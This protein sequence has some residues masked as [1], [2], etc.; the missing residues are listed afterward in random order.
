MR[1]FNRLDRRKTNRGKPE[2]HSN[3]IWLGIE[4][5]EDRLMLSGLTIVGHTPT[6]VRNNR[7]DFVD[8]AFS[9]SIDSSTFAIDDVI[10]AGP[11]GAV[12]VTSVESLTATTYRFRFPA[13]SIRGTYQLTIGPNVAELNGDLLDQNGNGTGGESGDVYKGTLV[14]VSADT[15]FSNS[16][17]IGEGD[18]S[19]DGKDVLI[20]GA[21]V[22][23]DGRHNFNSLHLIRGAVL[24]HSAATITQIHLLDLSVPVIVDATSKIDVS[25]KG[26]LPGHTLGNATE[27][28]AMGR[29]GGSYGGFGGGGSIAGATNGLY[30]DYANPNELGS[31]IV[32]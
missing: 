1:I 4:R 12:G 26:Y 7:L 2:S 22:I 18:T 27:G 32:Q 10:I 23:I 17:T 9:K 20:D 11:A 28:G 30:G 8:V 16:L 25:G 15:I 31:G 14:Y 3:R 19:Y 29:D 13:L 6:E 21:T 5:L 24:T